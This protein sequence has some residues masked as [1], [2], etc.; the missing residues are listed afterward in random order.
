M[1]SQATTL[2]DLCDDG[3][4]DAGLRTIDGAIYLF[5]NFGFTIITID[6]AKTNVSY[7]TEATFDLLPNKPEYAITITDPYNVRYGLSLFHKVR[8][9]IFRQK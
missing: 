7:I 5:K 3:K 9:K 1:N 2:L 8:R 4:I 6:G